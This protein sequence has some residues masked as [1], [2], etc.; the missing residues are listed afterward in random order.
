MTRRQAGSRGK[1]RPF[2]FLQQQIESGVVAVLAT[3]G[4]ELEEILA[5]RSV[6]ADLHA[7]GIEDTIVSIERKHF[8]VRQNQQVTH[9]LV[10]L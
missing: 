4:A 10:L 8:E 1:P 2:F 7:A 3:Q 6:L 9:S 5:D